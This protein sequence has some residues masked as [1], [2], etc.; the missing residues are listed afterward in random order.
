MR[1]ITNHSDKELSL[2]IFNDNYFYR[3]INNL[4]YLKAL[5]NEEFVYTPEQ[6]EVAMLDVIDYNN[7]V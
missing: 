1:D 5:I 2:I 4:S 6:L 3:E 7:E